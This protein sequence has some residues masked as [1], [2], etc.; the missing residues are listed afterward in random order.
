MLAEKYRPRTFDEIIGQDRIVRTMQWY[1]DSE[2]TSGH[3]FLV[4]GPSGSGKT[5]LGQCAARYW[6]IDD[7]D[8]QKIQSAT[9]T[10]ERLEDL[11]SSAFVYGRGTVGRKCYLIDEIHTITG[12]AKDRLLSML[13]DLPA[14]VLIVGT[15]TESDWTDGTLFSRFV[16]F[17]VAKVKADAVARHLEQIAD[18]ERLPIPPDPKWA[19]KFVKYAPVGLNVRDL[20]NQLPKHL[21]FAE[22]A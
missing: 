17:D 7:F 9:C 6:G 4:T 18:A 2:N 13:E 3:C 16:R 20:I 14:H 22:A 11:A 12:R 8:I 19:D 21:L 1:L 15:T 10:A 5:A